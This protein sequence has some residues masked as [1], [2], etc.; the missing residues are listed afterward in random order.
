MT[1]IEVVQRLKDIALQMPNVRT[2]TE[3][4]VYDT[5]N[6][7]PSVVYDV[8]HLTQGQHREDEEFDYY[9]FNMFYISR[10][11]DDYNNRLQVQSIGKTVLSNIIREFC[12]QI[13]I[14]FPDETQ[15]MFNTFTE[16]FVDLCAGVYANVT[17]KINK[18]LVCG[19]GD[20]LPVINI[21]E[22]GEFIFGGY[23][24]VVDVE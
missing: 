6:T 13:D 9:V 21:T 22:N 12:D 16:K 20:E 1:L 4:D 23:K 14:E 15:L 24:I 11:T 3:G 5:L 19:D 18:D 8:F 17:F 7:N 10:L 2:A